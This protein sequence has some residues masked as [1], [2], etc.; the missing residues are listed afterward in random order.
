MTSNY[1]LDLS[2]P[3]DSEDPTTFT[4]E[5]FEVLCSLCSDA[6][7][8]RTNWR[9]TLAKSQYVFPSCDVLWEDNCN[10]VC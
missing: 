1:R 10:I 5:F 6:I 7:G 9:E 3:S 8:Q 2:Q 4:C